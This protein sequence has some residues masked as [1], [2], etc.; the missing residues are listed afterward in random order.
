MG[1][2]SPNGMN[3]GTNLVNRDELDDME[4]DVD[5][6]EERA[7]K[8]TQ[9]QGNNQRGIICRFSFICVLIVIYFLVDFYMVRKRIRDTRLNYL[10]LKKSSDR[11]FLLKYVIIYTYE[12]IINTEPIM[13]TGK[14]FDGSYDGRKS[15]EQQVYVNE[16]K[17][18]EIITDKLFLQLNLGEDF[19][20]T[21]YSEQPMQ[22]TSK[23]SHSD[24]VR[25]IFYV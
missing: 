5:R 11:S 9:N 8:L 1:Q 14:N 25:L 20:E 21:F 24:F 23:D 13:V 22:V 6:L 17:I 15:Y 12:E 10:R 3:Q 4:D 7:R 2:S 16:Q 18:D 19:C